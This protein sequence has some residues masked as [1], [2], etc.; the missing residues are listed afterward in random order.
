VIEDFKLHVIRVVAETL[1]FSGTAEEI[2]LSQSARSSRLRSLE[3]ALGIAL[4]D[5]TECN[6]TLTHTGKTL[7]RHV[8]ISA[9]VLLTLI[10]NPIQGRL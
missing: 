10:H 7:L 6:A 3:K 9:S 4:F 1:N 5:R 8:A 2:H